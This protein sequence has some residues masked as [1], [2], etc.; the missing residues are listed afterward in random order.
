[1]LSNDAQK[2]IPFPSLELLFPPN[3]STT[4]ANK[5]GHEIAAAVVFPGYMPAL[6][7]GNVCA[8]LWTM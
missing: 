6:P 1:M 4:N 5:K 7:S 3:T 8:V 2:I